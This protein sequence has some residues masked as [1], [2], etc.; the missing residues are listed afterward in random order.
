VNH[1]LELS[2]RITWLLTSV[3]AIVALFVGRLVW[4][5]V[6]DAGRLN[7]EAA[8]RRSVTRTLYG[9]RGSIVDANGIV[10][11]ESVER[12]DITAS[13]RYVADFT[14]DGSTVT[15]AQAL[16]QIGAITG[17]DP[18]KLNAAVTADATSDFAYLSKGVTI[19]KLRQ[20]Q[21][22]GIPW[23]YS[24]LR[25]SR[26]YPRGAVAG[27]LTG[28]MGTDGP[29]TGI[30]YYKNKCLESTNG[31]QSFAQGSD[32]IRIPGSTF[33]QKDPVDG[34]TIHLTIDSDLQW[35]ASQLIKSRGEE[36]Q[37]KWATALVVRVA[38]GHILA[39]ADWP[40]VD[41][42]NVNASKVDDMGAR[43]FSVPYEPG[44]VFKPM[45]VSKML[46][47]GQTTQTSQYVVPG[48]FQVAKGKFIAD[49]FPHGTEQ[50][51]TTGILT[52]SSNIG[53]NILA[54]KLSKQQRY[55]YLT[56]FGVGQRTAVGFLGEDPGFIQTPDKVDNVTKFTEIFGQGV[57]ATSAQVASIY[58][59]IG[60]L[61]EKMP[62]TL[63]TGCSHADGSVTDLPPTA[64]QR[65]ISESA[66]R[67]T[68]D[69]METVAKRGA[70]ASL[71]GVPGYRIAIKSGTA[72]V[73]RNGV[74]TSDRIIS[75]AGVAPAEKPQFAVVVT[76][77]MPKW[78]RTS[79]AAATSFS[80]LMGQILKYYRVPPSSGHAKNLPIDW[81]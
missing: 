62:L 1:N 15:V 46:D 69:I 40:N 74:Y 3:F 39:A 8:S 68:I 61:G 42:N 7:D 25:P 81:R 14:R 52:Y 59:T 63:V 51:T 11:A 50:W 45:T 65:V 6:I 66:A 80:K 28:F 64:G 56:S 27:N 33:N 26:T 76:Y 21:A 48:R 9:V 78:E 57:T 12:Y 30:E 75:V 44:S 34:G 23:V 47:A 79:L 29:L 60:N 43:L 38:D 19:N 70:L 67:K 55:D 32:G 20:V 72:E 10:L 73:A 53:M 2:R 54:R 13:P 58:Q 36:L 5:Q 31:S 49:A 22:L 24:E 37:A 17:E 41:P 71:V 77:A 18:A 35:F 4:V 16:A